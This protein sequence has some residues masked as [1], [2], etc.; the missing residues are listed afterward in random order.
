[1][2]DPIKY[3]KRSSDEYPHS[4][5]QANVTPDGWTETRNL[6][7]ADHA[8]PFEIMEKTKLVH[9]LMRTFP[10]LYTMRDFFRKY[11]E[12]IKRDGPD[13]TYAF[14]VEKTLS[15]YNITATGPYLSV[16]AYRNN[17]EE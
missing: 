1:M 10:D 2:I 13:P 5:F 11:G 14:S 9:S 3:I 17:K 16:I 6:P 8:R 12:L 7:C 4:V 15:T